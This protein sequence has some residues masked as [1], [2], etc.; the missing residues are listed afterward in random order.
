MR[1]LVLAS[2]SRY[3]RALLDRLRLP[4]TPAVPQCDEAAVQALGLPAERLVAR[5]ARDK[6]AS[7]APAFPDALVIGSDQVVALDGEILGKPGSPEAARAQLARLAGR[8]HRLL[9]GLAVCD[10]ATG[11]WQ[12]A[13]DVH[14]MHV[15]ALSA[16]EIARYVAHDDP[17]D[18]AGAYKIESL[19]IALFHRIVGEDFTAIVGLPLIPL[20]RLLRA[21]GVAVP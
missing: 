14:E 1:N 11:A 18:C 6:A 13:L 10:T 7:V 17:I 8:S 2:T 20:T 5:L 12:E 3:R 4:Y 9:T 19:G 21:L 16:D 15:R